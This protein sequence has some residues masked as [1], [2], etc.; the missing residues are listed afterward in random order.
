MA[1]N[2]RREA[3][4]A[5]RRKLMGDA[6]ADKVDQTVYSDPIM[7]KFAEV[8]QETIFGTLWTR[9]G[10]DLKT[11]ALICVISDAAQGRD[12]ELKLHL[13]FARNQGWTEDELAEA[14]LHLAG[15]VGAPLVREAMLT[16]RDTFAEMRAEG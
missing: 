1:E 14:L 16:A 3:G 7:Q 11:R 2:S 15:Y 9:P 8:T 6:F 4:R 10:L 13:R 5:M 12:P